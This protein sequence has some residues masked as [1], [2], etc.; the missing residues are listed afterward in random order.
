[1]AQSAVENIANIGKIMIWRS[2]DIENY[3]KQRSFAIISTALCAK[4]QGNI[5][6]DNILLPFGKFKLRHRP[7]WGLSQGMLFF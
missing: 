3:C 4:R 6:I 5:F 7:P 1:L 2:G